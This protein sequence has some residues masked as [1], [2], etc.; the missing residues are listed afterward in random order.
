ML[1]GLRAKSFICLILVALVIFAAVFTIPQFNVY[2]ENTSVTIDL[3]AQSKF[4]AYGEVFAY[5]YGTTIYIV[6]DNAIYP[7]TNAFVGE[8]LSIEINSKNILVLSKNGSQTT[9]NYFSYDANGI[10]SENSKLG[11][12]NMNFTNLFGDTV[13][14]FY[15]YG[16]Y[17]GSTYHI[18]QFKENMTAQTWPS[19]APFASN[20]ASLSNY[21]FF[22]STN[23]VY[24]IK[25]GG[26]Y[27]ANAGGIIG[28]ETF[29]AQIT[30]IT[31]AT[32]LTI[33]ST[34]VFV[35]AASGIYKIDPTTN[36]ATRIGQAPSGTGEICYAK[37]GTTDYIFVCES[38]S[39][40]QYTYNGTTCEYYNKFNNSEYVHPNTFDLLYVAKAT[41][42]ANLYSSP[43]NMQVTSTL[44]VNEYFLVLTSVTSE[45]SGSYFYIAKQDGTKGYIKSTTSF[46][47]LNANSNV[48]SLKIGLFAQGLFPT[49]QIYKYPYA[50][51]EVL[52]EVTI[53]DELIVQDNVAEDNG[54]QVW[55]YYRVSYVKDG[56]ILTGYVKTTDVSPY[57]SLKAP[58]I[59]STVKVSSGSI[60]AVVY[61]YALPSEDSAKIAPLTDGEE[62]ELAEE[63][64]KNSTWTK[65][66]YKGMYAYVQTSQIAKKG[67][68][69]VQ[70]T[71]IV[72][73][74]VVVTVSVVMII[75]LRKKRRI[76]F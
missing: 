38:N 62:L 70:I 1:K 5:T 76:G 43:R 59:L 2:A 16:T 10:K 75:L 29:F 71:L 53:Y 3:N 19:K 50:N 9:L 68:T 12:I 63:Y 35:N 41:T 39:I 64:N 24:A 22:E 45:E 28:D 18:K 72:I 65:V 58:S 14:N 13:G 42:N 8:C 25:N 21:T 46:E 56:E 52:L 55:N 33:S 17:T 57:T 27:F 49:T 66:V 26:I 54:V 15:L 73:S 36:T 32:S 11:E 20:D 61:L 44:E 31:N 34:E 37:I 6:K 67:L 48:E 51:S 60:G 23:N 69:P 4:D 40:I 30:D 74:C 47:K 7:Y